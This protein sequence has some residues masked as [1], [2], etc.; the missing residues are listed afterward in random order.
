MALISVHNDITIAL[1]QNKQRKPD[2]NWVRNTS[3]HPLDETET[4]HITSTFVL[5]T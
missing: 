5:S 2:A 4:V 1:D 3:F